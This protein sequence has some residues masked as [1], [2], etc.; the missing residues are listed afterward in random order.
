[1]RRL[2]WVGHVARMT[3]R[4]GEYR[5]LM[6]KPKGKSHLEDPGVGGEKY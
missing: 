6:R 1:M 4:R 3:K 2:G 5:I